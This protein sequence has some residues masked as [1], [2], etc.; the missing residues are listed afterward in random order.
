MLL[1]FSPPTG[2]RRGCPEQ[3]FREAGKSI[4]GAAE[5]AEDGHVEGD[6]RH[7]EAEEGDRCRGGRVELQLRYRYDLLST[8]SMCIYVLIGNIFY[9]K[10]G[11]VEMA[12]SSTLT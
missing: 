1:C 9:W 8:W 3:S 12:K 4:A 10:V 6:Q 7:R 2:P 5:A 11:Y